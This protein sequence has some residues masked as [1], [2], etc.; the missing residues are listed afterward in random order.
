MDATGELIGNVMQIANPKQPGI[1][2]VMADAASGLGA[3]KDIGVIAGLM[4]SPLMGAVSSALPWVG[5]AAS[6]ASLFTKAKKPDFF[7]KGV[8][9][10]DVFKDF[11]AIVDSGYK[12]QS[13]LRDLLG[14]TTIGNAGLGTH[15]AGNNVV[16]NIHPGA[17]QGVADPEGHANILIQK[18][19]QAQSTMAALDNAR[20]ASHA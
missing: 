10:N 17:F 8:Y 6:L 2:G 5:V 7:T 19:T 20:R 1:A 11:G 3:I 15:G 9:N 14:S 16:V 4:K 12:G 13:G 18:I